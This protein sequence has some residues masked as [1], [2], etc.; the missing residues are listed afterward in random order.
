MITVGLGN[1]AVAQN[2]EYK[3]LSSAFGPT[4]NQGD[5]GWCYAYSG[6]DLLTYKFRDELKG[7]SFS[8]LQMALFYNLNDAAR[9]NNEAGSVGAAIRL[10]TYRYNPN[11]E[12][13]FYGGLCMSSVDEVVLK[14]GSSLSV[15]K[16]FQ[17]LSILK[18]SYDLAK[19]TGSMAPF[20]E[21]YTQMSAVNTL[22]SSLSEQDFVE[23]FEESNKVDV[24]I[25]YIHR[26]CGV[27]S[28]FK[29]SESQY[30]ST[31]YI[32]DDYVELQKKGPAIYT[33]IR[34]ARFLM[35]LIHKQLDNEN[36]VSI[37]YDSGFLRPLGPGVG[38]ML[39]A[40]TVVGRQKIGGEC[41]VIIRNSWGGCKNEK[42]EY[43]YS[44]KVT[45]C[46]DGYIWIPE[47][48]LLN[49][50]QDVTYLK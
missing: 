20:R 15:K 37:S 1:R 48:E 47:Q 10:S 43:L 30:P 9:I 49:H 11:E 27:N 39:H 42:N 35:K 34:D 6:S 26:F 13:V 16:R 46:K 45:Q 38:N 12:N 36:V 17:Q 22:V 14:T 41:N 8:P 4:F 40:S 25:R 24:G 7:Q 2:C 23:L 5:I 19:R 29:F 33:P 18:A 32:G 31:Y 3:N 50:L 44:K 21:T 28:R